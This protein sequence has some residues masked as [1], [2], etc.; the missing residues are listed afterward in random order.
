MSTTRSAVSTDSGGIQAAA[1]LLVAEAGPCWNAASLLCEPPLGN[2]HRAF[3]CLLSEQEMNKSKCQSQSQKPFVSQQGI[4]V[5][6]FLNTVFIGRVIR[7]ACTQVAGIRCHIPDLVGLSRTSF[8]TYCDI[9]V[10]LLSSLNCTVNNGN[11][12]M[13]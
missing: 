4:P 13:I 9:S 1:G 7:P 6:F 12:Q 8:K 10:F 2:H 3:G 11:W 5:F